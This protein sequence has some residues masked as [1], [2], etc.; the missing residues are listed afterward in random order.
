[1]S[2]LSFFYAD[3][4]AGSSEERVVIS[5][6]FTDHDGVP[7]EWVL[8]SITERENEACRKAAT[9]REKGRNGVAVSDTDFNLYVAK[10]A[11]ASVVFP[12]L[13]DAGLQDSYNVRGAEELLRAMLLPGEYADLVQHVQRLNGFEKDMN[14]MVDEVKN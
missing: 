4:A 11:V 13:K 12:D 1:M 7:L 6:R 3:N 8:R 14:E 10:M 2:N 9:K 5:N